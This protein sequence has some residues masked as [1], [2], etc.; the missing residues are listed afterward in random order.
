MV[1][2]LTITLLTQVY[3]YV[4]RSTNI[5]EFNGFQA[6]AKNSRFESKINL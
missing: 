1:N 6:V 3:Q 2:R 4:V 5:T